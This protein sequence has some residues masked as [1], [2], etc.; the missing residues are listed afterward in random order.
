MEER[1]MTLERRLHI[2]SLLEKYQYEI[3]G[4]QKQRTAVARALIKNPKFVLAD[5]PTG[6]L[7]SKSAQNL[8]Q[9]FDQINESGQTILMVTHSTQAASHA[10]RVL[11]IIDGEVYNQLYRGN[12]TREEMFRNI[13]ST[14]TVLSD[15]GVDI[16]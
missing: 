6:A 1:L 13:V 4:G 16:G 11:F 8:L 15:G 3:S 12:Q 2:E 14:L 7:D 9:I 5:E 10:M